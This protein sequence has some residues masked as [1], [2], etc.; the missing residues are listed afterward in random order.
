MFLAFISKSFVE[1][2]FSNENRNSTYFVSFISDF[3]QKLNIDYIV[4]DYDMSNPHTE[5]EHQITI[6][7]L[8]QYCNGEVI[9]LDNKIEYYLTKGFNELT[10]NLYY[11]KIEPYLFSKSLFFLNIP[12]ETLSEYSELKGLNIISSSFLTDSFKSFL[13]D[14]KL[15]NVI[16]QEE[17]LK[18]NTSFN[19]WDCEN[20]KIILLDDQYLIKKNRFGKIDEKTFFLD[21]RKMLKS[22]INNIQS[23]NKTIIYA[24]SNNPGGKNPWTDEEKEI[25]KKTLE[26]VTKELCKDSEIEIYFH[27]LSSHSRR[28]LT[29]MHIF[30]MS[31]GFDF[32]L[33]SKDEIK[34]RTEDIRF[35]SVFLIGSSSLLNGYI[36]NRLH[37]IDTKSIFKQFRSY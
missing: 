18:G 36:V 31:D 34:V 9:K 24:I 11:S 6:G 19:P 4:T 5:I 3:F 8:Y 25:I 12:K 17:F 30:S 26:S 13:I 32:Q 10:T 33:K 7:A 29:N 15:N 37:K 28:L 16:T 14:G 23:R 35:E 27:G 21:L 22:F 2:I 1:S 20:S